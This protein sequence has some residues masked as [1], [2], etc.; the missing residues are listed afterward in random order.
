MEQKL[1]QTILNFRLSFLKRKNLLF[2]AADEREREDVFLSLFDSS[3]YSDKKFKNAGGGSWNEDFL[4]L[5]LPQTTWFISSN[6]SRQRNLIFLWTFSFPSS[7]MFELNRGKIGAVLRQQC[8]SK[9]SYST[10]VTWMDKKDLIFILSCDI[11]GSMRSM[12]PQ[13]REL[14][15]EFILVRSCEAWILLS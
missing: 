11:F 2:V 7:K 1:S 3:N 13:L 10:V 6:S 9:R 15:R 12:P 8:N 4:L 14:S 5:S